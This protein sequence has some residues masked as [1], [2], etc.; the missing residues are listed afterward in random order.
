MTE[1]NQSPDIAAE[2]IRLASF[3]DQQLDDETASRQYIAEQAL[4][5]IQDI[6]TQLG[7]AR[8]RPNLRGLELTVT[9]A[10]A[11]GIRYRMTAAIRGPKRSRRGDAEEAALFLTAADDLGLTTAL[12]GIIDVA[13]IRRTVKAAARRY[14]VRAR[15][16]E[17]GW[18]L[19]IKDMGVTQSR[20]LEEAGAVA[21]DYI[22]LTLDVPAEYVS[23]KITPDE[24]SQ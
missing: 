13:R 2:L 19:R 23:V 3:I 20:T 6:V 14:T 9:Q 1:S 10:L 5:R 21:R 7:A 11:D 17:T 8:R 12:D 24:A 18:E 15:R 22:A 4:E 16:W